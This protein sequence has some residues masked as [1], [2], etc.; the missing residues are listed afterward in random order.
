[1]TRIFFPE[2]VSMRY[3]TVDSVGAVS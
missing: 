1:M 2:R 3:S